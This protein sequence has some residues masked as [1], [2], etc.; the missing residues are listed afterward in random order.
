MR[1]AFRALSLGFA[2]LVGS[3]ALDLAGSDLQSLL[4]LV[5]S[6]AVGLAGAVMAFRGLLEFFGELV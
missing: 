5:V 3:I 4:V 2:L 1:H 6:F